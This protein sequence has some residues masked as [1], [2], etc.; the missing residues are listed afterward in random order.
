MISLLAETHVKQ[1][2][3]QVALTLGSQHIGEVI[4]MYVL[5]RA[6]MLIESADSPHMTEEV[7]ALGDWMG[8]YQ[9]IHDE[10]PKSLDDLK[11]LL[12]ETPAAREAEFKQLLT[13]RRSGE[14]PAFRYTR[15]A[16]DPQPDEALADKTL[17]LEE[18]TGGKP[19][20]NG[21]REYQSGRIDLGKRAKKPE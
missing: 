17:V 4:K 3:S 14:F 19:D 8:I 16:V 12:G 13:N 6:R 7:L 10:R 2:E 11:P 5:S 18:L 20:P 15:P 1:Q 21:Y 9:Q